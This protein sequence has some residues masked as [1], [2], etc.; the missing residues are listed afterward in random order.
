MGPLVKLCIV[1]STLIATQ[2]LMRMRCVQETNAAVMVQLAHRQTKVLLGALWPRRP[3]APS[4]RLWC[5]QLFDLP[6]VLAH[7]G[8]LT[9]DCSFLFFDFFRLVLT[10]FFLLTT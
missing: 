4:P 1:Q 9:F 2:K 6:V 3:I 7:V 10:I 8:I 5:E